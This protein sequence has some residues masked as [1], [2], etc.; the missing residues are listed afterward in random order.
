MLGDPAGQIPIFS[1][2][3]VNEGLRSWSQNAWVQAGQT[4]DN[5]L[6]SGSTFI[7]CKM[8]LKGMFM[9]LF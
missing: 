4:W 6:S 1:V 7:I 5:F 8:R 3:V 2:E 9:K